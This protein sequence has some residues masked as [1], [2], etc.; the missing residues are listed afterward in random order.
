M[1]RGL[2]CLLSLCDVCPIVLE[3]NRSDL[4]FAGG[5]SEFLAFHGI[6]EANVLLLRYEANMVFTAD[7][8]QM[9]S[10]HKDIRMQ[11]CKQQVMMNDNKQYLRLLGSVRARTIGHVLKNKRNN[12]AGVGSSLLPRDRVAAVAAT[13]QP[14]LSATQR[15]PNPHPPTAPTTKPSSHQQPVPEASLSAGEYGARTSPDLSADFLATPPPPPSSG[16][17]P[18]NDVEVVPETP[19]PPLSY[20]EVVQIESSSTSPAARP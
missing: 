3:M 19:D 4:F 16:R 9:D 2:Y 20:A 10:K 15:P 11:Q 1:V 18:A 12:R 6:S 8:C 13:A 17:P 5:W 7:G 14:A